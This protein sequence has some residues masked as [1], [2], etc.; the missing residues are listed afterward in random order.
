MRGL[1]KR[2]GLMAGVVAATAALAVRM[3]GTQ[4]AEAANGDQ[5][6]IGNTG[7][8]TGAQSATAITQLSSNTVTLNISTTAAT[9]AILGVTTGGATDAYGVQ[10]VATGSAAVGKDFAGLYGNAAAGVGV[11]GRGPVGMLGIGSGSGYGVL[12]AN[13]AGGYGVYGQTSAAGSTAVYG[14]GTAGVGVRGDSNIIG[15]LGLTSTPGG[16]GVYGVNGGAGPAVYGEAQGA[17]IG[18]TAKSLSGTGLQTTS[19][20]G[21]ALVAASGSGAAASFIGAVGITGGLTVTGDLNVSG[22]KSAVVPAPDG[23]QRRVYCQESPQPWFEDFGEASLQG[24]VASVSFAPDFAAI[25]KRDNYF[26][27]V[28]P[29]G[30]TPGLF[31]SSRTPSGFEVREAPGGTGSVA[32]SYR[33]VCARSDIAGDRLP[34]VERLAPTHVQDAPKP[35]VDFS[36]QRVSPEQVHINPN[37]APGEVHPR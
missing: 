18:V 6:I 28:Q 16:Y 7:T 26:V 29:I 34:T 3:N 33:V 5:L 23:T 20:S 37:A 21:T 19:T 30:A 1:M 11:L 17:G 35:N 10:G 24:G 31:V 4:T 22:M 13:S 12:G 36:P 27:F 25:V 15:V 8:G 9:T 14:T 32:F 2:R